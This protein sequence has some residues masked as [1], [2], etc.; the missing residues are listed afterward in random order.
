MRPAGYD[1]IVKTSTP[2]QI[3][4]VATAGGS[5]IILGAALIWLVTP[6]GWLLVLVGGLLLF[7]GP[8]MIAA[9]AS[10]ALREQ[11]HKVEVRTFVVDL[12]RQS[13]RRHQGRTSPPNTTLI[14]ESPSPGLAVASR[15]ER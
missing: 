6:V 13:S 9:W 1:P 2:R 11:D 5:M 8:M 7:G 15:S 10:G 3:A 12:F 4:R 14:D